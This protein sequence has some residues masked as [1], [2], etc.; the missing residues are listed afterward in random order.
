[1]PLLD[2]PLY[3]TTLTVGRKFSRAVC[4]RA[5]CCR[6]DGFPSSTGD[7]GGKNGDGE[8]LGNYKLNHPV[9]METCVYM[10]ETGKT[11]FSSIRFHPVHI[12]G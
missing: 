10:D 7:W 2:E 11:E 3:M 5:V 8:S 6:A 12:V 9:L 1:M 4:Q